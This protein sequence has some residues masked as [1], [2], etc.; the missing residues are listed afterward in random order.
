MRSA[1]SIGPH[2]DQMVTFLGFDSLGDDPGSISYQT[3]DYFIIT[4]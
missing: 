2:L 1:G 4:F 3:G